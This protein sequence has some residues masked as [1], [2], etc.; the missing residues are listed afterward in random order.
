[1]GIVICSGLSYFTNYSTSAIWFPILIVLIVKQVI[2]RWFG[3]GF[4]KQKVVPV[5][6]FAM[7]GL[8]TGMFL[9]KVILMSMGRGFLRPY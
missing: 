7:M 5:V 8:M 6:I 2:Y 4:F 1:V 9:Y 3:V